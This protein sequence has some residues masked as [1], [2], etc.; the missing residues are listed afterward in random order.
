[1]TGVLTYAA[2]AFLGGVFLMPDPDESP[3][4]GD[5]WADD[6]GPVAPEDDSE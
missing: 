5:R 1:M 6:G 4:E 3:L 2:P